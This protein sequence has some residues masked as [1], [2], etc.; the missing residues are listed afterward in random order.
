MN[1]P[2]S[3][4]ERIRGGLWGSLVGDALGVP[5]EFLSRA[6]VQA[7]PV[8]GM[9]GY[10]T[11]GQPPGTW[12]DDSS[13]LI[14]TVES[15]LAHHFSV[16]DMAMRFV[17]WADQAHW[18]PHGVVF[19]IGNA[20]R[21]ALQRSAAGESPLSC[22][23]RSERDNGNGSLMRILPVC[24]RFA[25]SET[26]E[27]A[28]RIE[29]ASA[30]THAHQRSR[31]ACVFFGL[32]V[33]ELLQGR[34]PDAALAAAQSAFRAQFAGGLRQEAAAFSRV[35]DPGLAELPE[36]EIGSSGYV[37]DTIAASLWC[38]LTTENFRD[39]VLRAVNLGGD[40]DTTGCV[41][42]GLAGVC[43]GLEAIPAE[44][45]R[46]LARAAEVETLFERL[47]VTGS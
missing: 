11:H 39:C 12:S 42:G 26:K 35:L 4:E 47:V 6:A 33:R 16:E 37:M 9:R 27:L 5:V 46:A 40:T 43:Y 44:W 1:S 15:L 29:D 38:L 20:T 3:V 13:M 30:I 34:P 21:R 2:L 7:N 17:K 8:T 28:R 14:C 24:L 32:M 36:N 10:G 31:M 22:G 19:D 18:T 23:G 41:A 25:T 45:R